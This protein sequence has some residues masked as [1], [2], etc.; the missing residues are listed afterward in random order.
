MTAAAAMLA[1]PVLASAQSGSAQ[2]RDASGGVLA[3][4][5]PSNTA[6]STTGTPRD[7]TPGN[8]PSTATQ[9]GADSVTGS[10]TPRMPPPAIRPAPPPA[11]RWT[12]RSAPT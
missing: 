7:G 10:R 5:A 4:S 6:P 9:R 2:G 1:L 8:P 12:A 11:A 3:Q